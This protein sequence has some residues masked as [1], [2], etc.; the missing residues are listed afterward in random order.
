M[1]DSMREWGENSDEAIQI[2][3]L[4]HKNAQLRTALR[5]CLHVIEKG[6][7]VRMMDHWSVLRQVIPPAVERAKEALK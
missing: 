3:N 7:E 1:S 6:I 2:R 5:E 4:Q